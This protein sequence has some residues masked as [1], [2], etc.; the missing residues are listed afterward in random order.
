MLSFTLVV[1]VLLHW[2]H[3]PESYGLCAPY[4]VLIPFRKV[5]VPRARKV[6]SPIFT[7][8]PPLI[9]LLPLPY[10]VYAQHGQ[11]QVP[12]VPSVSESRATAGT[13]GGLL[14][15]T[16]CGCI[17]PGWTGRASHHSLSG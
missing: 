7:L 5:A 6:V 11:P 12:A 17:A 16:A 10:A 15:L 13:A 1:L 8:S 14:G 9:S 4:G 2:S 3:L